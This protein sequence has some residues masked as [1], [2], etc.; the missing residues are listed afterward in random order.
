MTRPTEYDEDVETMAVDSLLPE[1][2]RWLNEKQ[3]GDG[4]V[5][6]QLTEY[7]HESDGYDF[8]RALDRYYGWD[9]NAELVEILDGASWALRSAVNVQT[10]KWIAAYGVTPALKIGDLVTYKGKPCEIIRIDDKHGTYTLFSSTEGH[11]REGVGTHGH[12]VNWELIDGRINMRG[13]TVTG[14]LFGCT[15]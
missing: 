15:A 11:V 8:T 9:P 6:E 14:P 13:L 4:S 12:I 7:I 2:L 5:R 3:D 10:E 1:V